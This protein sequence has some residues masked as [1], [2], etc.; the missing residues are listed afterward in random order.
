MARKQGVWDVC[1]TACRFCL[2]Y[3]SIKAKKLLRAARKR[4]A[5]GSG[6]GGDREG[7]V[8]A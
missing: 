1:R 6:L 3:D 5:Q 4:G 8:L 2:L 7:P